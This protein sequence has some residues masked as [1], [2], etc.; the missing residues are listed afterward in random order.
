MAPT[1][2]AED[3]PRKIL[4]LLLLK[5]GDDGTHA[6]R[7]GTTS[8]V[9]RETYTAVKHRESYS[10]LQTPTDEAATSEKKT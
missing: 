3:V 7:P 4:L 5:K 9:E 10:L 1:K 8:D 6:T 2:D